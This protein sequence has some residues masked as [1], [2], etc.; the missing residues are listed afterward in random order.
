MNILS[1]KNYYHKYLVSIYA[2]I[3]DS[4]N[5]ARMTM[6]GKIKHLMNVN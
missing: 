1:E 4:R 3:I 2:R 6:L 5:R